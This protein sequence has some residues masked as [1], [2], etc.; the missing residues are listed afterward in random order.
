MMQ[1][2][3]LIPYDKYERLL[4]LQDSQKEHLEKITEGPPEIVSSEKAKKDMHVQTDDV[5]NEA[6]ELSVVNKDEGSEPLIPENPVIRKKKIKPPPAKAN[7]RQR[8]NWIKF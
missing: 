4:S 8:K 7:K 1:K 6:A 5:S 2:S 3:V